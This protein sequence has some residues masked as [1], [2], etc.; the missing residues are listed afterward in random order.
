M[1]MAQ[2]RFTNAR[3]KRGLSRVMDSAMAW[4]R[5]NF[6]IA[7]TFGLAFGRLLPLACGSGGGASA[8][9]KTAGG[10]MYLPGTSSSFAFSAGRFSSM[11][12]SLS[13]DKTAGWL[14]FLRFVKFTKPPTADS[15]NAGPLGVSA[16][17]LR[18]KA[19]TSPQ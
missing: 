15:D 9:T 5:E 3:A 19:A 1:S 17:V 10:T 8:E 4:R 6:G 2:V 16:L 18:L 13:S 14:S 12:R 7:A 11:V